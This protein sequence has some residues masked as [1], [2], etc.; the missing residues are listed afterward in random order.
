[1]QAI[2]LADVNG[3][4]LLVP[5]G[6]YLIKRTLVLPKYSKCHNFVLKGL[7]KR[8]STLLFDLE[9]GTA[10][11]MQGD[12]SDRIYASIVDIRIEAANTNQVDGITLKNNQSTKVLDNIHIQGFYNNI[13]INKNWTLRLQDVTS[14]NALNCNLNMSGDVVNSLIIDGGSYAG[15]KNIN[16]YIHGHNHHISNCDI[17]QGQEATGGIYVNY[18]HG[19]NITGCY[20]ESNSN[21]KEYGIRLK[22]CNGVV[23]D[24]LDISANS[25]VENYKHIYIEGSKGIVINGLNIES[26]KATNKAH[27]GVYVLDSNGITLNSPKL[28]TLKTAI[29][30]KNSYLTLNAPFMGSY[31]DKFI[32]Q[33]NHAYARVIGSMTKDQIIKSSLPYISVIKV[34]IIN[35]LSSGNTAARPEPLIPGQSYLDLSL[36]KMIYCKQANIYENG[37][38]KTTGTWIDGSGTFV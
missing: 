32:E 9:E 27:Y 13:Y 25:G 14:I 22:S 18:C 2:D 11:D 36:G 16:M 31:V 4:I 6:K 8:M 34:V 37:E 5:E 17:S 33:F 1:M 15:S 28:E 19:L 20:F 38:L 10:I 29:Y 3:C 24:G 7:N 21:C 35:A 26:G 30:I 12:D 23:I